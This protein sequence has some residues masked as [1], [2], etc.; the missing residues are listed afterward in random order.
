MSSEAQPLI[1]RELTVRPSLAK[2]YR[3]EGGRAASVQSFLLELF[4]SQPGRAQPERA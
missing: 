2:P 4:R 1:P 3:T